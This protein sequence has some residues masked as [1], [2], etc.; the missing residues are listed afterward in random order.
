LIDIDHF[1]RI[2][3]KYGTNVG[4][5]VLR[6]TASLLKQIVDSSGMVGRYSGQQFLIVLP[7][8]SKEKARS[9]AEAIAKRLFTFNF[10]PLYERITISGSVL[11]D[12]YTDISETF[13]KLEAIVYKA[14]K[15]GRNQILTN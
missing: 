8:T 11:W 10:I 2:N 6:N 4:D 3:E 15:L 7:N 5:D 9:I 12:D 13:E 1:N 14:K